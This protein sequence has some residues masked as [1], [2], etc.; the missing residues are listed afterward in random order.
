[1]RIGRAILGVALGMS[2]AAQA[3]DMK[4]L[5]GQT[6]SN[7]V[8]QRFDGEGFFIR[9]DG[10][11]NHVP[12]NEISAE[13]RGHYKALSLLP[14][15]ESRLAGEKEAPAGPNDLET[16]SGEI[17]RNVVLKRVDEESI[18]IAHDTGMATV[19]FVAIPPALHE[20]YRTGTPVVPDPGIGANDL[21]TAYGQIFRNIEIILQEPDGLTFRHDG[22]MTK[23]GFPALTEDVRQKYNYDP[24]AGWKYRRDQA[25]QKAQIAQEAAAVESQG[26]ALVEVFDI[27][28]EKLPD[29][30]FRISFAVKNLT[31]RSQSVLATLQDS[32]RAALINRTVEI[33]AKAEGKRLQIEV[34]EIQPQNLLIA[35]GP[36][37]TN[38]VLKW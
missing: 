11:S 7:I 1:M 28:A 9:Y 4:T 3:E 35:C 24:I 29:N 25:A 15:Q 26:P 5:A 34:P 22:G 17:Y 6:Y 38:T 13:L 12:Y 23:V 8:V 36:Y 10:G 2:V 20:K 32:G 19:S 30:Q 27:Q 14:I 31:D 37:R 18:L 33:N 21:V 16:L